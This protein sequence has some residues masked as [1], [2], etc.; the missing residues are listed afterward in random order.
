MTANS[1]FN[2]YID[3]NLVLVLAAILWAVARF[4]LNRTRFRRQPAADRSPPPA[5]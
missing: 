1:I 4:G 2:A 5:P 3:A